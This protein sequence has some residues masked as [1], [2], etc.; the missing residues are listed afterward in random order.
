MMASVS[1]QHA[2]GVLIDNKSRSGRPLTVRIDENV[3]EIRKLVLTDRRVTSAQL[4][5]SSRLSRGSV[6]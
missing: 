3:V 6:H 5:M 4:S 2:A 1:Q